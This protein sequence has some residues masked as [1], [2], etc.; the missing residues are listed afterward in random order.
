[1]S[2]PTA[3]TAAHR[4]IYKFKSQATPDL[5]MLAPHGDALLRLLGRE[6]AAKGIVEP[7]AMAA[8][9]AAI[10]QAVLAAE[11]ARA[12]AEREAEA[13]G[14]SLAPAEGVGL[15][16]RMWPMV[17]MLRRAAAAEV[18]VVWGV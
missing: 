4:V 5:I 12:Q 10:E 17:D 9:M 18:P 2:H 15:R 1:M 11:A 13:R 6:P 3:T 7:A 8:A 16:Q 14:E